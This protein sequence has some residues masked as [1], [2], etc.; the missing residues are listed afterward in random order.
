MPNLQINIDIDHIAKN[1]YKYTYI[2]NKT[3]TRQSLNQKGTEVVGAMKGAGWKSPHYF[4]C[5][6]MQCMLAIYNLKKSCQ[7][8]LHYLFIH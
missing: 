6:K 3:K 4:V 7:S 8:C 2:S 1:S 5:Y